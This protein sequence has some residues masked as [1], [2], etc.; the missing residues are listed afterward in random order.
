MLEAEFGL[1]PIAEPEADLR[2]MLGE[3]LSGASS[4]ASPADD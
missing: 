1:R 4:G 3:P 2:A